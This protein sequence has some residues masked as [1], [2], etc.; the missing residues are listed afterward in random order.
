MTDS[1][2]RALQE[3]VDKYFAESDRPRALEILDS[4]KERFAILKDL[5][6]VRRDMV[7]VS[8]GDIAK[9]TR[10][11]ERDYRDIIMEAEY[12]LLNG[13]IVKR[14]NFD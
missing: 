7:I 11:A 14:T 2:P 6:R 12:E 3:L 13:K 9:L 4:Y 5:E 1:T 8:R 10:A